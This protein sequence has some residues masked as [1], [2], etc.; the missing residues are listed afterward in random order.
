M[1][2]NKNHP[3]V[4]SLA[5]ASVV[6]S[7]LLG[8]YFLFEP[9]VAFGQPTEEFTVTQEITGEIA[10]EVPPNDI[11][12]DDTI[13]GLTGGTANGSTSVR[14]STNNPAGYTLD[15]S[16]ASTTA[17]EYD[18]GPASIP[19]FGAVQFDMNSGT[20]GT[21]NAAFAFTASSSD[22]V[23]ALRDSGSSC[24]SGTPS[25][26]QCWTLPADASTNFTLVNST[27]STLSAG[28]ETEIAFR[29][30]VNA[31]PNPTLPIG[32][33]TATATLTAAEN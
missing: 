9:V 14:V 30:V 28:Q 25:I 7:L 33:Y 27:D 22:V 11:T 5:S 19:N 32:F 12:M 21:N 17:M 20:V 6:F 24:G 4:T 31:N 13:A 18:S 3:I 15:I 29:V 16:F 2:L 23:S 10:F 1:E 8:M 26:D